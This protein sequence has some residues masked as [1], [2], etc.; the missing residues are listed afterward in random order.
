MCTLSFSG[1][2]DGGTGYRTYPAPDWLAEACNAHVAS[3]WLKAKREPFWRQP[4]GLDFGFRFPRLPYRRP[5]PFAGG[6]AHVGAGQLIAEIRRYANLLGERKRVSEIHWSMGAGALDEAALRQ[7]RDAIDDHFEVVRNARFTAGIDASSDV[8]STLPRLYELGVTDVHIV[9]L[10]ADE[11][12]TWVKASRK[13]GFPSISVQVRS[14][15]PGAPHASI[16]EAALNGATR[17][18][19]APHAG[20]AHEWASRDEIRRWR[21]TVAA[22]QEARYQQVAGDVYALPGDPYARASRRAGLFR[23]PCGYTTHPIGVLLAL[24]PAT[25]GI[26]G[27]LQYQNHRQRGAYTDLL[28][29]ALLPIERG[30]VLTRDDLVRQA[31]IMGLWSRLAIDIDVIETAYFVRFPRDFADELKRLHAL[32]RLGLVTVD[33]PEIR[34]T[35]AGQL[36]CA[37]I[38]EVFDRYTR[39]MGRTAHGIRH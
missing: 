13:I 21:Q 6:I 22:L 38:C 14:D 23:Q 1:D 27:A 19:I 31:I 4:I 15:D 18:V 24:G 16:R 35:A 11:I 36:H 7:I 8:L 17:V 20:S 33:E 39:S 34:I 30:L 12:R 29:N 32:E 37:R 10:A 26:V 2:L 28:D 3:T 5:E 25:V 9:A